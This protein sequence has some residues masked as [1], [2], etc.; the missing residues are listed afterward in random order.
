M[1]RTRRCEFMRL[2]PGLTPIYE[3]LAELREEFHR[4]GRWDDSNAKL[5]EVVKLFANVPG[6]QIGGPGGSSGAGGPPRTGIR[7]QTASLL[8]EGREPAL[9]RLPERPVD[10]RSRALA[11][12][13]GIEREPGGSLD[14]PGG[15][16]CLAL[17]HSLGKLPEPESNRDFFW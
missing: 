1:G 16:G 17:Y 10:F 8:R 7:D 5:D 13:P 6:G 12:S 11:G 2:S 4:T 15:P 3:S 14:P 9:L